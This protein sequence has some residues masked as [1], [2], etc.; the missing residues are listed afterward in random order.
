MAS[1]T[2]ESRVFVLD[3]GEPVKILDMAERMIQLS[4][5][6]PYHDIDIK[7]TGLRQGEKLHEELAHPDEHLTPAGFAGAS[8]A[9]A[10]S[11]E[12]A[13]VS[14]GVGKV[15]AA[16]E[17]RDGAAIRQA[18]RSLVPEYVDAERPC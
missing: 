17:A 5:L 12:F 3:M 7:I 16:A 10:R 2:R 4:G 18:L 1:E 9:E 13:V 8:L 14:D 11:P 15:M 6:R